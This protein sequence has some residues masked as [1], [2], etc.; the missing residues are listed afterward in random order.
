M[1]LLNITIISFFPYAMCPIEHV[2]LLITVVLMY[3][4]NIDI[5]KS[6]MECQSAGVYFFKNGIRTAGGTPITHSRR[7]GAKGM[8]V[9]VGNRHSAG[10]VHWAGGGQ[11]KGGRGGREGKQWGG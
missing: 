3:F 4:F 8:G 5:N 1:T 9:G 7:E 11:M 6:I 2:A 10:A